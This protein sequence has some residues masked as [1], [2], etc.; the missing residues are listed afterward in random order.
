MNLGPDQ[1][2]ETDRS[3]HTGLNMKTKIDK[4]CGWLFIQ[5]LSIVIFSMEVSLAL[6]SIPKPATIK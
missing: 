2:K 6:F 1:I 5:C 3:H 4:K